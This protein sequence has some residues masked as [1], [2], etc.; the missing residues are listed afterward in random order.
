MLQTNVTQERK[1]IDLNSLVTSREN[2]GVV[3]IVE[4]F[5]ADWIFFP[6]LSWLL[7]VTNGSHNYQW[8]GKAREWR[9]PI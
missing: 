2:T 7:S 1:G 5:M 8:W 4:I 9:E 6:V 3:L